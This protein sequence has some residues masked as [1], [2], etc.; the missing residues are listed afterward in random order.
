MSQPLLWWRDYYAGII[1]QGVETD[2]EAIKGMLD[3]LIAEAQQPFNI[4]QAKETK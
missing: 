2:L 4:E 3:H 1:W